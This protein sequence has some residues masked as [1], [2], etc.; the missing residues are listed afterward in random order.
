MHLDHV[1]YP[2]RE[3]VD[4]LRCVVEVEARTVRRG[5]AEPAHQRLAAMV[6]RADGDRVEIENLRDVVW[7]HAFDVEAD[8]AGTPVGRRTVE[9]HAGNLAE[10]LERVGVERMLVLLDRLETDRLEIVDRGPEP[11]P[12]RQSRGTLH[13]SRGQHL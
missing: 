1:A 9:R 8:D 3:L 4:V 13:V 2:S 5:N 6:T 10:L 12:F 11:P 7:M